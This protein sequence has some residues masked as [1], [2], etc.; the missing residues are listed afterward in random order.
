[1]STGTGTGTNVVIIVIIITIG[2]QSCELLF[3]FICLLFFSFLFFLKSLGFHY[4][5]SL[6]SSVHL[7]FG[8]L[9]DKII[10]N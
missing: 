2:Y 5:F 4:F 3:S 1:M 9:W 8:L 6:V 10:V 7:L